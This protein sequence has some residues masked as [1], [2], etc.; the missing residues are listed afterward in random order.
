MTNRSRLIAELE[1]LLANSCYQQ[2]QLANLQ[3]KTHICSCPLPETLRTYEIEELIHRLKTK[4][5]LT[6]SEPQND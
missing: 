4:N 6:L 5:S 1:Y 3:D 2:E